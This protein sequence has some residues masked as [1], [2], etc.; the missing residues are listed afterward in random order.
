MAFACLAMNAWPIGAAAAE[1]PWTH[2]G[3]TPSRIGHTQTIGPRTP[4]I[5]WSAEFLQRD[6]IV[7]AS[8]VIDQKGRILLGTH[9]GVT[10]IDMVT[11][12]IAWEATPGDITRGVAIQNDRVVWGD[13]APFSR[14]YCYDTS[15]GEEIWSFQANDS[16]VSAPVIDENGTIYIDNGADGVIYALRLEDGTEVWREVLGIESSSSPS[17]MPG[18]Y[19]LVSARSDLGRHVLDDG[20]RIWLFPTE[21][22]IR[23]TAV[24]E[25]GRA[26]LGSND[27][28][29]Y[30]I[31]PE[32]GEEVWRFWCERLNRGSV[33]VRHDGS[34]YTGTIAEPGTLFA[35]TPAGDEIW[36]HILE[37][38]VFNAPIADGED[39]GYV[40]TSISSSRRGWVE[41]ID[42]GG[43]L[44]WNWELPDMCVASP[45]L[46]PDGTLY[47]VCRDKFL[48]AFRDP[49]ERMGIDNLE[50]TTGTVLAGGASELS[51][52][53][54]EHLVV[55]SGFGR[56]LSEL[57][58]MELIVR[59]EIETVQPHV[60][61]LQLQ[62]RISEPAGVAT[63]QLRNWNTGAFETVAAYPLSEDEPFEWIQI[64]EGGNA[65][66]IDPAR[67][68]HPF[69][70]VELQ[71]TH[72]VFAPFLAFQFESFIDQIKIEAAE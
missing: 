10:A 4:T 1:D 52:P 32:T 64:P 59:G 39:T 7:E 45:M 57:H 6:S 37:G 58:K 40:T 3:R 24:A 26:L 21:R 50:I 14:V 49:H 35:I 15:T 55:R 9:H 70:Q 48:Y 2:W 66:Y 53:D 41:A 69:G 22:D 27:K 42:R 43:K 30:R 34:I 31:N 72:V 8:P 29:L 12:D 5:A 11:Q 36:R 33:A 44:L 20:D 54:D 28:Y 18:E 71:L 61:R 62:S 16:F 23:G 38:A 51:E 67:Y 17:L 47:I 60:L 68:I 65:E 56:R 13:V 19:L 46:A 63:V 25:E